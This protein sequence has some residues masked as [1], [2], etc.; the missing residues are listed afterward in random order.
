[1]PVERRVQSGQIQSEI[2]YRLNAMLSAHQRCE[3]FRACRAH[4][5]AYNIK[6]KQKLSFAFH[7]DKKKFA[8][9]ELVFDAR[10]GNELKI[11]FK[12]SDNATLAFVTFIKC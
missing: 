4:C 7:I 12:I 2:H 9:L 11:V 8:D 3:V 5:A 10:D 6:K 1:M